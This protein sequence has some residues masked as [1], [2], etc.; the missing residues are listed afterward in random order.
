MSETLSKFV[1]WLIDENTFMVANLPDQITSEK[2]GKSLAIT[3]TIVSLCTLPYWVSIADVKWLWIKASDWFP[4]FTLILLFLWYF[5][6][7][8][9]HVV[10]NIRNGVYMYQI[11][12]TS[13]G[14]LIQ[15]G[16]DNIDINT[17]TTHF[18]RLQVPYSKS[19]MKLHQQIKRR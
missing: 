11:N 13:G 8:A 14:H 15:E 1:S 4:K 18:I 16:S 19:R 10:Q 6:S 3:E 2:M 5:T 17:E 7:L 9:N 12:F